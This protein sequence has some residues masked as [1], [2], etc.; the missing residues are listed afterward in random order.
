MKKSKNSPRGDIFHTNLHD[1]GNGKKREYL[2]QIA[3]HIVDQFVIREKVEAILNSLL[4][5]EEE[6]ASNR[7]GSRLTM[8]GSYASFLDVTRPSHMM[9]S[10]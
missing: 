5:A 10:G 3:S 6:E 4:S 7:R 2:R 8:A 9:V 1:A